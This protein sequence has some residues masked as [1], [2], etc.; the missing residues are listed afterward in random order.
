MWKLHSFVEEEV[1]VM[2][3]F[4]SPKVMVALLMLLESVLAANPSVTYL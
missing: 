4:Q 3:T 2:T 1:I